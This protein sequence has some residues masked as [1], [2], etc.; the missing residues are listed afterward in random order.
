MEASSLW[1]PSVS[2]VLLRIFA[3]ALLLLYFLE[4]WSSISGA[5][6]FS[7]NQTPY[8]EQYGETEHRNLISKAYLKV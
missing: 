5:S 1:D 2:P 3:V 6:K 8:V 4:Y 7:A